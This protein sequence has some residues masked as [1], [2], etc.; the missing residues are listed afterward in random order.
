[1]KDNEQNVF[2]PLS[3][4]PAAAIGGTEAPSAGDPDEGALQAARRD[5][6]LGLVWCLG[7]VAFS[8]ASY[9]LASEG[10]KYWVATG[11][12]VWGAIQALRGAVALLRLRRRRGEH[13]AFRRTAL[14][15]IVAATAIGCLFWF[16]V[17]MVSPERAV[18][19][20]EEQRVELPALRLRLTVPAGYTAVEYES[21][22]ET[23]EAYAIHRAS[24]ANASRGIT[25]EGIEGILRPD[26]V[27][28]VDEITDYLRGQ[29]E[30]FLDG[31]LLGEPERVEIG[32]IAMMKHRG[33]VASAPDYVY[34]FYDVAHDFSLVTL[35]FSYLASAP[36][37][38]VER[39]VEEQLRTLELY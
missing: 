10:G 36:D 37:P 4:E 14:L 11:A 16:S 33:R 18:L 5:V 34:V 22:P 28:V 3:E 15:S 32:G 12:V 21:T 7:G 31:G 30:A 38:A 39:Q 35:Y 6:R 2:E 26:S 24:A 19:L 17:R 25:V 8:L 1:M 13:A 23:D 27:V 9:F 29:A 20:D